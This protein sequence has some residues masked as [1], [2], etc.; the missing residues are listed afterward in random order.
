MKLP[1]VMN[2]VFANESYPHFATEFQKSINRE[3]VGAAMYYRA[4]KLFSKFSNSELFCI[5]DSQNCIQYCDVLLDI[6]WEKLNTGHWNDVADDWRYFYTFLSTVKALCQCLKVEHSS[7]VDTETFYDY[8]EAVETCDRGLIMG[9]PVIENALRNI[10]SA[11]QAYIMRNSVSREPCACHAKRAK[12]E[13]A[14]ELLKLTNRITRLSCPSL[15]YFRTN[16][17]DRGEPVILT[18]CIDFW[19]AFD[20]DRKWCVH[21]LKRTCGCRIVPVEI[22]SKYTDENW[23]QKL[24][25]VREFIEEFVEPGRASKIAYLAQ[26]QLFDQIPELRRDIVV[27]TYCCLGDSTDEDVDINAWFGPSG[28]VS[29]LHHDP[30][31]NFLAQ[32]VGEKFVKLFPPEQSR[33][34]YPHD[35]TLLN[36]TSRVDVENPDFETFPLYRKTTVKEGVLRPGDMLYIPPKYWHFIKSLSVSFSVSFW[37]K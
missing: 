31:R 10:V 13:S 24:M 27:P 14:D 19:P 7:H 16:F 11:L 25:S 30:K 15:E 32:V 1:A 21:Y 6:V 12:L 34:L 2:G 33:F 9:A 36:N 35:E 20:G 22:G 26:H 5:A 18:D 29:P 3:I 23:S 28:T 4:M 8:S 17:M 37:W